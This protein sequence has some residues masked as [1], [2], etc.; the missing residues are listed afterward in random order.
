[1]AVRRSNGSTT[2]NFSAN[3]GFEA[4]PRLAVDKRCDLLPNDAAQFR[5]GDDMR[6]Q[7]GVQPGAHL[8]N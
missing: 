3:I 1:M 7:F 6:G 2:T 4:R 8:P 5:A